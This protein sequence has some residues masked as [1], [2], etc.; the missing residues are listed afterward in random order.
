[1][2]TGVGT[3]LLI[4]GLASAGASA[5]GGKMA[6]S[7]AKN[8]AKVQTASVDKA[9][10]FN[11]KAWQ[12]QQAALAPYQQAGQSA[13]GSLMTNYGGKPLQNSYAPPGQY[14]PPAAPSGGGGGPL[15]AAMGQQQPQGAPGAQMP[16]G[17]SMPPAG[18]Q[19]G[20]VRVKAPTGEMAM[21]PEN[22]PQLQMALQR[23]A[24]RA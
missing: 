13:L 9:Q 8:A 7:S 19:G 6:S 3:A 1:M 2:P 21:M 15:A 24:V 14:G 11:E 10:Q 5:V 4:G 23:G 18:P 20:M 16:Q 17:A 12:Q 22:S